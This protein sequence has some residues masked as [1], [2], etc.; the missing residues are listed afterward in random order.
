MTD[1]NRERNRMAALLEGRLTERERMVALEH[2]SV[3]DE[4]AEVFADSAAMLRDLEA[5]DGIVVADETADDEPLS[6]HHAEP[7]QD[8]KYLLSGDRLVDAFEHPAVRAFLGDPPMEDVAAA[9]VAWAV[10]NRLPPEEMDR[11]HLRLQQILQQAKEQEELE[12]ESNGQN[13]PT[14]R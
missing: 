1:S 7:A 9:I 2:L 14:A 6:V 8:P 12:R 4:D 13:A 3:S 11:I 5:Q 10:K